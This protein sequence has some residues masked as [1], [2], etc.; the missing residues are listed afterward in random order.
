M[1]TDVE[2]YTAAELADKIKEAARR[3]SGEVSN[4][5]R[6][7]R[8]LKSEKLHNKLSC[9]FLMAVTNQMLLHMQTLAEFGN[10]FKNQR[11]VAA[12]I[13]MGGN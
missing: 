2:K 11:I 5:P 8:L 4:D 12:N 13:W 3:A 1:E 9:S 10:T 6:A 7:M